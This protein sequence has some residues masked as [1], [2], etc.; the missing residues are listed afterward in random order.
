VVNP[1]VIGKSAAERLDE[2]SASEEVRIG[3]EACHFWL[4][5]SD[6]LF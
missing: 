5:A 4:S 6:T 3:I 2:K 1:R